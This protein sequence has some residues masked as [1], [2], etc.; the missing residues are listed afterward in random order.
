METIKKKKPEAP[1][2]FHKPKY[3]SPM[4]YN[5]LTNVEKFFK[6]LKKVVNRIPASWERD[7][8]TPIGKFVFKSGID[9]ITDYDEAVEVLEKFLHSYLATYD[10]HLEVSDFALL[11]FL[12]YDYGFTL[13][14]IFL[15]FLDAEFFLR[16][17]FDPKIKLAPKQRDI[18]RTVSYKDYV[19]IR[20]STASGK[21]F[22]LG[23]VGFWWLITRK[24]SKVVMTAPTSRQAM[25]ILWSEF[26]GAYYTF[27]NKY[28][29]FC[30]EHWGDKPRKV[31]YFQGIWNLRKESEDWQA[32][33]FS[34]KEYSPE[35]IQGFHSK[36]FMVIVDEASGVH[37]NL[38]NAMD[39]ILTGSQVAKYVL[40]SNPTRTSGFFYNTQRPDN[41]MFQKIHIS[42]F[43]SPNVI[44]DFIE[45]RTMG[46][47]LK[48]KRYHYKPMPYRFIKGLKFPPIEYISG[49]MTIKDVVKYI[50]N[51]GKDSDK[52]RVDILGEFPKG[53]QDHLMTREEL[54]QVFSNPYPEQLSD[55]IQFG[56]DPA[57]GSG[58]AATAFAYRN[59]NSLLKTEKSKAKS[60][61][62]IISDFIEFY[63]SCELPNGASLY[64]VPI[65]VD[66]SGLGWNL[67]QMMKER[68][69]NIDPFGGNDSP[70]LDRNR[71]RYHNR[72]TEAYFS[73]V[74]K[75]K[76]GYSIYEPAL[77]LLESIGYKLDRSGKILLNPKKEIYVPESQ[78]HQKDIL[79]AISMAFA[80]SLKKNRSLLNFNFVDDIARLWKRP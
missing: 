79:D 78:V 47:R 27:Y 71:E 38:F 68:K 25:N 24:D 11:D 14:D 49:L 13:Y 54:E 18:L 9:Q 62:A 3:A 73:L 40:I 4:T 10:I 45:N 7:P 77:S 1:K 75:L 58:S 12:K 30:R 66:R 61:E 76:N 20:S 42:G 59:G 57:T 32:L 55:D 29:D 74:E 43:D 16:R 64:K 39:R 28:E 65:V 72:R 8:N 51:Y 41:E 53:S 15:S 17:F 23:R 48:K 2:P 33:C 31:S 70:I 22:T 36:F 56:I 34:V 69:F 46:L 67:A 19:S 37:D 63:E 50:H 5:Q 52:F 26:R 35:S 60:F 80:P 21:S 6:N 44:L